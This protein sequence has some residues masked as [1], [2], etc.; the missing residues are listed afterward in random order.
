M[1]KGRRKNS[2]PHTSK[3][4]FKGLDFFSKI[5]YN[6]PVRWKYRGVAQLVCAKPCGQGALELD[7]ASS[8]KI[9]NE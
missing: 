3:K 8:T 5:C 7:V 4:L 1:K 9:K 6:I 2:S